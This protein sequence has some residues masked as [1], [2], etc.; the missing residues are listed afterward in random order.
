VP[1]PFLGLANEPSDLFPPFLSPSSSL[2][3]LLHKTCQTSGAAYNTIR[4]NAAK[5]SPGQEF[6]FHLDHTKTEVSNQI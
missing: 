1:S 5:C 3:A 6:W 4:W 2:P